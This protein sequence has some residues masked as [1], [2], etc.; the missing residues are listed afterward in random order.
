VDALA[1]APPPAGQN[2]PASPLGQNQK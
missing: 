1:N 2:P